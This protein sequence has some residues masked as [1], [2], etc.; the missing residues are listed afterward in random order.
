[1]K[2]DVYNTVIVQYEVAFQNHSEIVNRYY[3]Y[4]S[5]QNR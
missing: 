5:I 3:S 4:T 1:M 2:N